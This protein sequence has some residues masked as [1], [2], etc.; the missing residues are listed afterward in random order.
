MTLGAIGAKAGETILVSSAFGAR[1]TV[2]L[3]VVTCEG[4]EVN[5]RGE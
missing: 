5:M 2:F 1:V 3:T 4:A